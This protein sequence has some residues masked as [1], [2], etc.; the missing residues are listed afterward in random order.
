MPALFYLSK[1]KQFVLF[2]ITAIRLSS[3][4]FSQQAEQPFIK[5][6]NGTREQ[7]NVSS[8]KQ[9]IVGSTCK[10]CTLS[11]NNVPVKV[12]NSGG[13]AYELILPRGDTSVELKATAGKKSITKKIS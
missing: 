6:V 7:N 5:L 9:F 2:F 12:Y 3:F 11:I 13:F 8:A 4:A 10:T 1:M